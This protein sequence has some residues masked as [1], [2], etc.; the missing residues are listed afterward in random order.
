MENSYICIY[1]RITFFGTGTSFGVPVIGC[2]CQVCRSTDPRDRRFRT[3]AL[4]EAEGQNILIDAGPDFRSQ[5]LRSGTEHLDAILLT[6]HHKDHTGGLDDVRALNFLE[7]RS[8]P[9]FCEQYVQKSLK[10]EYSYAF[11]S[12]KIYPGS[13]RFQLETVSPDKPFAVNGVEV[14]PVR[15]FHGRLPILGFRI[16]K[17]GYVTDASSIP[18]E[19]FEK[20]LGVEVFVVNCVSHRPHPSHFG[21]DQALEVIERVGAKKSFITHISH[22]LPKYEDFAATLPEGVFPAHDMLSVEV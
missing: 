4:I 10:M 11:D 9:I 17:I 18:D 1:M 22:A 16:G 3:S 7:R 21:L 8:L 19:E 5:M 13:P 20:L 14:V 15:A 6:H 2:H 12:A